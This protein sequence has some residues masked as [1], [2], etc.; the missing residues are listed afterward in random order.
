MYSHHSKAPT[1]T[2]TTSLYVPLLLLPVPTTLLSFGHNCSCLHPSQTFSWQKLAKVTG[3]QGFTSKVGPLISQCFHN[4]IED[5]LKETTA[6][7]YKGP[8]SWITKINIVKVLRLINLQTFK[9]R[10]SHLMSLICQV[11]SFITV[12][13]WQN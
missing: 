4:R 7:Q 5:H 3:P 10:G 9:V 11:T 2:T 8:T 12:Q 1:T 6:D 13:S